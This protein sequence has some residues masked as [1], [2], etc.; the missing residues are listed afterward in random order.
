MDM[1]KQNDRLQWLLRFVLLEVILCTFYRYYLSERIPDYATHIGNRN[2]RQVIHDLTDEYEVE[3]N[4]SCPRDFD[5]IT[6]DFSD[7]D[8]II[9]GKTALSVYGE[10]GDLIKYQEVDNPGIDYGESVSVSFQDIGGGKAGEMYRLKIVEEGTEEIALGLLGYEENEGGETAWVNG[11][12]QTY[13]VSIGM[14]TYTGLFHVLAFLQMSLCGLGVLAAIFVC[15]GAETAEENLFLALAVPFGI[16][17]LLFLS[18]N[19]VADAQAHTAKA[20]RYANSILGKESWNLPGGEML[21]R[22]VDAKAGGG[23]SYVVNEEAQRAW[24]L[25]QDWS[26][27]D[28]ERGDTLQVHPPGSPGGTILGYLPNVLGMV[29]GRLL[30]LGAYPMF[31]LSKIISFAAY[32]SVCYLA[33]KRTPILKTAFAFTAALPT[34]LY[35]AVGITYDTVTVSATLLMCAYIFLWWDRDLTGKEVVALGISAAFVAGCKGGYFLPL[36]LLA[37]LVPWKRF[38]L[39]RKKAAVL[40]CALFAGG[41]VFLLQYG[42]VLTAAMHTNV[43]ALDAETRYGAGYVFAYPLEFVKLMVRTIVIRGD[44]Y[45]GHMLGDRTAWTREHVEWMV[46]LPFLVLLLL[47][48]IRKEGEPDLADRRRRVGAFLLLCVEFIGI[49]I[50]LMSDTQVTSDYIY[51]VQGRYFMALIPVAALC[52]RENGL[53]RK[54]GSERK[55]YI[56]YSMVQSIYMLS[57]L[58]K[59]F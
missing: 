16:C 48:G 58:D 18:A 53:V 52:F 57:L 40:L 7:H 42:E 54:A 31:F 35:H 36:L 37:L 39:S 59:Y 56:C 26:W 10:N 47:A 23:V 32:V 51:G 3:Q 41:V 24:R 29:L 8:L 15:T 5:F 21:M 33:I 22:S 13:A 44:A 17:M 25:V 45:I 20:Y 1:R 49:H 38:R 28:Q 9:A 50:I 19:H 27:F 11:E 4:F 6:L 30:M 43:E 2:E 14:H 55:L 12:R 34:C 46:I